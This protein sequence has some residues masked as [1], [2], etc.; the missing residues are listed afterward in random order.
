MSEPLA[1]KCLPGPVRVRRQHLGPWGLAIGAD[2]SLNLGL[3]GCHSPSLSCTSPPPP[4]PTPPAQKGAQK[5]ASC[6]GNQCKVLRPVI[7]GLQEWEGGAAG[8][9][10]P[11]CPSRPVS[12]LLPL[13]QRRPGLRPPAA[14]PGVDEEQRLGRS[15]RTLLPEAFL[16]AQSAGHSPGPAYPGRRGA[17]GVPLGSPAHRPGAG[18][19]MASGPQ[20]PC[21]VASVPLL[22]PPAGGIRPPRV[23]GVCVPSITLQGLGLCMDPE[24]GRSACLVGLA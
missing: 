9:A 24:M 6:L 15:R 2:S 1:L 3:S 5:Q 22:F 17:R 20:R 14:A 4:M 19:I 10:S 18:H 11:S 23:P 16:H 7:R 21:S 12:E 13:A 8:T